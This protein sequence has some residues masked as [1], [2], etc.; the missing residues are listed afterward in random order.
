MKTLK[1]KSTLVMLCFLALTAF[2]MTSCEKSI[3]ST[4]VE[5]SDLL[6]AMVVNN[7]I[8]NPVTGVNEN[9]DGMMT[10]V[11]ALR[12]QRPDE[13]R[14]GRI[15]PPPF[16][17]LRLTEEQRRQIA[18]FMKEQADCEKPIRESYRQALQD[19]KLTMDQKYREIEA[20]KKSPD[21][22]RMTMLEMVKAAR[23]YQQS[24]MR[25]LR[26]RFEEA[27]QA[28]VQQL[29]RKIESILTD[30]QLRIW[31]LWKTTGKGCDTSKRP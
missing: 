4:T 19:L 29:H 24:E 7:T 10:D 3:S 20:Y 13:V 21:Y 16:R 15:T 14:P 25:S 30:E 2:T 8:I 18:Q 28:C 27:I 17:C 22:D 5:S 26:T 31:N 12:A 23:E 1:I 9:V 6:E 11:E